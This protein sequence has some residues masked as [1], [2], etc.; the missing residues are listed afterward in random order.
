MNMAYQSGLLI[1]GTNLNDGQRLPIA[2]D[3][4]GSEAWG[5]AL[6]AAK[7][8]RLEL[9]QLSKKRVKNQVEIEATQG[10]K[11]AQE[12]KFLFTEALKPAPSRETPDMLHAAVSYLIQPQD[13]YH[14]TSDDASL[15]RGISFRYGESL[16]NLG[17]PP[18]HQK[19]S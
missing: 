1:T 2:P 5:R 9:G 10:N 16:H 17:P 13:F 8:G 19:P 15:V 14:E 11:T 18:T 4:T 7:K 6:L 3:S 12:S